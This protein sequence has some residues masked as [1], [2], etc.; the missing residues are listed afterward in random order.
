MVRS[1]AFATLAILAVG[2]SPPTEPKQHPAGATPF[3][4]AEKAEIDRRASTLEA[5]GSAERADAVMACGLAL[6][7]A[8]KEGLVAADAQMALPWTLTTTPRQGGQRVACKAGDSRGSMTVVA[9]LLCTDVND[10]KCHPLVRVD[11]P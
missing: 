5:A 3:T 11:R 9:D 6:V 10:L 1:F 8:E 4:E 7:A 2:C